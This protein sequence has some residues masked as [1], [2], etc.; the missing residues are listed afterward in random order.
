MQ[1]DVAEFC[2]DITEEQL[3][4]TITTKPIRT[5]N[6]NR[7]DVPAFWFCNVLY[8][9]P[10]IFNLVMHKIAG[11]TPSLEVKKSMQLTVKW[12]MLLSMFDENEAFFKEWKADP[13]VFFKYYFGDDYETKTGKIVW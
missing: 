9:A 12:E 2:Y 6:L 10:V 5:N 8:P 13:S 7:S 11:Y 4:S 1:N 3:L